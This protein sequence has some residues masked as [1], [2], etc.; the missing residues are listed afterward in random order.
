M[1]EAAMRVRP[2]AVAGQFYPGEASALAEAVRQCLTLAATAGRVPK[3]II[4][5]H[6]GYKYS[7]PV[8]G[9]AYT[10]LYPG[11]GILTRVVL[12][13]PSHRV[14]FRGVAVPSH[15]SFST[16]LG[17]VPVDREAVDRLLTLPQ[18]S[19]ID[20][21]HACEHSLEVHLPFLQITL[22]AFTLVPL[23]AGDASAAEVAEV[24]D[25]LWGGPETLLVVSSDL[26][27]YH[28]SETARRLDAR[29]SAAIE[30][31]R[32]EDISD[33]D[34]CGAVPVSGLLRVAR[35]RG[36]RARVLDLR[37]S[38]DTA[39]P[40]DRVVGYGAYAFDEN[41]GCGPE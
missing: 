13:G 34:A 25:A 22:A 23:V 39:G 41:D 3:A 21:A 5:P 6:A 2:P 24:F 8:A 7:G 12:A 35:C 40:P 19:A 28:D 1:D 18:V 37:N 32:G 38:G 31:L 10:L 30:S 4:V 11:R 33:T 27:H 15:S 14:A 17:T 29:T 9:S 26:S 20:E 16:P 36:L